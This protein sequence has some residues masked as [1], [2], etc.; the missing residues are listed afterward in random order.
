MK[1]LLKISYSW[2]DE[3]PYQEFNSF[4]EAW[5]T[6][7]KY[8]CNEAEIA[9]IEANDETCEIGLTLEKEEDRGRISLHYTY[10]NSYCYYDV[11]PQENTDKD[12]IRQPEKT[13]AIKISMK[14]GSLAMANPS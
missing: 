1:W 13:D 10:D 14:G 8:A 6:A 9:S 4:E 12:C 2:G 11:L 3:E 7:K 5:D